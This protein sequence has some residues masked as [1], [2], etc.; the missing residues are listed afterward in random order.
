MKWTFQENPDTYDIWPEYD[1]REPL[2]AWDATRYLSRLR[3]GDRAA[4]WICGNRGRPWRVDGCLSPAGGYVVATVA[5]NESGE[6]D[7][8]EAESEA[9]GAGREAR[10]RL[11]PIRQGL[12]GKP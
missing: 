2:T 7:L 11:R 9:D 3:P 1:A 8:Y 4:I 10:T 12:K 6:A 5:A